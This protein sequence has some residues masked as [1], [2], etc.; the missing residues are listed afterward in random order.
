MEQITD[1]V[2]ELIRVMENEMTRPEIQKALDLSDR[3][4]LRLSYITP[5]LELGIIE[6]T[7]PDKLQ[8]KLQ[9]YK[10][11]QLGVAIKEKL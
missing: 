9:K 7:L 6:M 2:K 8:S 4:H 10:L 1:Q 11:T 3:K 5:A